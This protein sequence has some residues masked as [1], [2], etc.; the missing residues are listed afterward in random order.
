L[1]SASQLIQYDPECHASEI[2][3]G[4]EK[5]QFKLLRR[6]EPKC[7]LALE[8]PIAFCDCVER[9]SIRKEPILRAWQAEMFAQSFAFIIAPKQV[10]ALQFWHDL[11]DEIV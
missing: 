11:P 10:A 3:I 6:L 7:D 9:R 2:E 5:F 4:G 1:N 8:S